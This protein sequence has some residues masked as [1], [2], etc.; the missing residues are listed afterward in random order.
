M[1][2]IRQVVSDV[3]QNYVPS[4]CQGRLCVPPKTVCRG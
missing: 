1:M 4:K 3:A 2:M